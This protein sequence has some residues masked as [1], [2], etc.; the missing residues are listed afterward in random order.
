MAAE[1]LAALHLCRVRATRLDDVGNPVA[2]PNN[3]VVSDTPMVLN[4][5]PNVEA[6]ADKTLVGGCDCIIATYRGFDK[7]KRFDLSLD[8][9]LMEPALFELMTGSAAILDGTDPI[10]NWFPINQFDCSVAAQPNVCFEGWQTGWNEDQQDATWPYIHWIFPSS[11]WRYDAA[12][13][14]DDFT[15]PKLTGFTRGN[16]NWGTGIFGDLPEAAEQLGGWFYDASIPTASCG[17]Q[18]HALT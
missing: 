16:S 5:T 8:M 6:G 14:Q 15:Q 10:G 12:T 2:G 9:G 7:L 11:F 4:V 3:V 18:S 1:C 17:Y 13:L